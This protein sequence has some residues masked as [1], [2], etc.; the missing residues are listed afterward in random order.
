MALDQDIKEF[1]D[2]FQKQGRPAKEI[3]NAIL[4]FFR[5]KG[6][7]FVYTSKDDLLVDVEKALREYPEIT[8]ED[9]STYIKAAPGSVPSKPPAGRTTRSM[10]AP[11]PSVPSAPPAAP[12]APSDLRGARAQ[13]RG[14][15]RAAGL[16]ASPSD[17]RKVQARRRGADRAAALVT[18]PLKIGAG[19]GASGVGV[20]PLDYAEAGSEGEE[21][22]AVAES[23][24]RES[25]ES[26]S[27]GED[28]YT[29]SRSAS[30]LPSG[31]GRFTPDS[32]GHPPGGAGS[33]DDE[34]D[35]DSL[36]DTDSAATVALGG[37]GHASRSRTPVQDEIP[38]SGDEFDSGSPL[39]DDAADEQSIASPEEEYRA[40]A[41]KRKD[42]SRDQPERA[43][44]GFFLRG[45][46]DLRLNER[47]IRGAVSGMFPE[48]APASGVNSNGASG[49]RSESDGQ[50]A[51]SLARV[52]RLDTTRQALYDEAGTPRF[53]MHVLSSLFPDIV[54]SVDTRDPVLQLKGINIVRNGFDEAIFNGL[55]AAATA[56]PG[57]GVPDDQKLAAARDRTLGVFS[58]PKYGTLVQILKELSFPEW[59]FIYESMKSAR[60]LPW[61]PVSFPSDPLAFPLGQV[62]VLYE[63]AGDALFYTQ[64]N[65]SRVIW[66][67]TGG[68]FVD[69]ICEDYTRE[70]WAQDVS[71][72]LDAISVAAE[73]APAWPRGGDV[74]WNIRSLYEAVKS[75]HGDEVDNMF[76]RALQ[77]IPTDPQVDGDASP[78]AG[79]AN[80]SSSGSSSASV[81]S[82]SQSQSPSLQ[83]PVARAPAAARRGVDTVLKSRIEA[84][85]RENGELAR[86]LSELIAGAFDASEESAALRERSTE[87][88]TSTDELRAREPELSAEI[89]RQVN[90]NQALVD[91]NNRMSGEIERARVQLSALQSQLEERRRAAVSAQQQLDQRQAEYASIVSSISQADTSL[92]PTASQVAS[93]GA[94]HSNLLARIRELQAT[95]DIGQR[96]YSANLEQANLLRQSLFRAD[97]EVGT[98]SNQVDLLKDQNSREERVVSGL[99][100][101]LEERARSLAQL[102]QDRL[103]EEQ[104]D[105]VAQG[106]KAQFQAML[107]QSQESA[108]GSSQSDPPASAASQGNGIIGA[109]SSSVNRAVGLLTGSGGARNGPV[110]PQMSSAPSKPLAPA[111]LGSSAS[112]V[113]PVQPVPLTLSRRRI[114]ASA[115]LSDPNAGVASAL[116][117]MFTV[118]FPGT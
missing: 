117:G 17:P 45:N 16:V 27:D 5:D 108:S 51:A 99:K 83:M 67:N 88:K 12:S 53:A 92:A 25:S 81:T 107:A 62:F 68:L 13:R 110:P 97:G 48:A 15:G 56:D 70:G 78:S 61:K 95:R 20:P 11:P 19:S 98:L 10:L 42:A 82:I 35:A 4:P 44:Y 31:A 103:D 3:K 54:K 32:G 100:S 57:P 60:K 34:R 22:D 96:Q 24:D 58:A 36:S 28:V 101:Q 104:R 21:D 113:Q 55:L 37:G 7:A 59:I 9:F 73:V 50:G 112:S 46:R 116:A 84:Q 72:L 38:G 90:V 2:Y 74:S 109:L 91:R 18:A 40:K 102:Q 111:P 115:G 75:K 118:P 76:K 29:R 105:L 43:P 89:E 71:E 1:Q 52:D 87:L 64:L 49:S 93:L 23:S 85:L 66:Q 41:Q 106:Q 47:S 39:D 86:K 6:L 26:S 114:V 94:L 80:S 79:S 77:G 14:A 33:E 69:A 30:P 8:W 65:K 63:L